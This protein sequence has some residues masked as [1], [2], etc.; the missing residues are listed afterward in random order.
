[1]QVFLGM[2]NFYRRFLPKAAHTLRPLTDC[3]KGSMPASSP[4]TWTPAMSHAFL[5]TKAALISST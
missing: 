5:D 4:V 2:V 3:L 1:M